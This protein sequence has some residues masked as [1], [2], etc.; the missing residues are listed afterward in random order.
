MVTFSYVIGTHMLTVT[1]SRPVPQPD[2]SQAKAYWLTRDLLAVPAGAGD[3][4]VRWRLH[5]SADGSLKVDADDIGGSRPD[6]ATTRRGF[7]SRYW[8]SSLRK[9]PR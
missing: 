5:W 9:G 8:P 4:V 7:P 1:T 6:C 2:L 3:P